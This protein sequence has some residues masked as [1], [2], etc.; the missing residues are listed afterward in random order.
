VT[1]DAKGDVAKEATEAEGVEASQ[2]VVWV[3]QLDEVVVLCWWGQGSGDHG[4]T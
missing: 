2:Q 4:L 1:L 3:A